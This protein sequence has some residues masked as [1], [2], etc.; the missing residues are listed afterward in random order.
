MRRYGIVDKKLCDRQINDRSQ[1]YFIFYNL[2]LEKVEEE[3]E[4]QE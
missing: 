3:E 1:I 2:L 4:E